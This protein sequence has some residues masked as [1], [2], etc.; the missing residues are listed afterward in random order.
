MH[1]VCQNCKIHFTWPVMNIP[2]KQIHNSK[3]ILFLLFLCHLVF[4]CFLFSFSFFSVA[5]FANEKKCDT[6]KGRPVFIRAFHYLWGSLQTS[7][8]NPKTVMKEKNTD[9]LMFKRNRF[10]VYHCLETC[11]IPKIFVRCFVFRVSKSLLCFWSAIVVA[12]YH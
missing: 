10:K 4:F 1:F 2:L 11:I 5:F 7:S 6:Q 3:N 8:E 9:C 12:Y